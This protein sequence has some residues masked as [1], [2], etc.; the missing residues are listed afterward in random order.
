[1]AIK[2]SFVRVTSSAARSIFDLILEDDGSNVPLTPA[3][4]GVA[5]AKAET[6]PDGAS[7]ALSDA[8]PVAAIAGR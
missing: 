1:M 2:L 5:M 8:G 3:Q 6:P 4:V 7:R